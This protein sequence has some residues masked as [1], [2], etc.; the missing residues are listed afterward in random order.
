[1]N[2]TSPTN[3]TI[4]YGE[5]GSV[6]WF[7][8]VVNY[9]ATFTESGDINGYHH[10][11]VGTWNTKQ[12]VFKDDINLQFGL[13]NDGSVKKTPISS[14]CSKCFPGKYTRE[15]PG[16][17]CNYI[18]CEPCLG[19]DYSSEPQDRECS[20]CLVE[21]EREMWG[22]NPF[23]GSNSCVLIPKTSA[24]YSDPW[25]IPSLILGFV[26]LLCVVATAVVLAIKLPL[27]SLQEENR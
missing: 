27:L 3:N 18:L 26:G 15:I 11:D 4:A 20:T 21:G 25:A 9:Q 10:V 13:N 14:S 22:N 2:F 5:S 7:Y 24:T 1:M 17:C 19:R 8:K 16:F 23:T 12:L 6:Q